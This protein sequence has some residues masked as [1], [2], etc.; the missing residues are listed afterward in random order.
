MS[1]PAATLPRTPAGRFHA[2]AAGLRDYDELFAIWG[3]AQAEANIAYDGWGAVGGPE[4]Y[5]AFRAA[6]DRADAAQDALG[7]LAA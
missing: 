6:E 5:A 7:A 4:A 3:A 2:P 1:T